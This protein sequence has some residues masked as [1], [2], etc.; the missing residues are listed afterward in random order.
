MGA[1]GRTAVLA[2]YHHERLVADIVSL[3]RAL[4]GAA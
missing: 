3:Y 1:A 2:R 4:A